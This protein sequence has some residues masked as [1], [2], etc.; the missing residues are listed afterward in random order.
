MAPL[1]NFGD[2]ARVTGYAE[3]IPENPIRAILGRFSRL[4]EF[5]PTT[6]PGGNQIRVPAIENTDSSKTKR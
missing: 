5:W 1:V 6:T 4:R 2:G 3:V